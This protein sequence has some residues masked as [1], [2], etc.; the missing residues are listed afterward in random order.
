MA[1]TPDFLHEPIRFQY[2]L[3][4][5]LLASNARFP[6]TNTTGCHT[7][8]SP[9]QT[10]K[11]FCFKIRDNL[12][13]S[14]PK[15]WNTKPPT[16]NFLVLWDMWNPQKSWYRSFFKTRNLHKHHENFPLLR[17]RRLLFV[18]PTLR[19]T[20]IFAPDRWP[21]STLSCSQLVYIRS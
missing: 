3:R 2:S 12:C 16:A 17:N 21:A 4:P 7:R 8:N 14:L 20:Q 13:F 6:T 9:A 19:L 5:R 1:L 10:K 11:N 15:L 18:I